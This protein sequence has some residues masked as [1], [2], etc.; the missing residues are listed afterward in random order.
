MQ[1]NNCLVCGNSDLKVFCDM[2]QMPLVNNLK[3]S[4]QEKDLIFPLLVNECP[5]CTHKQLSISVDRD[6]LFKDYLYQTGVSK[7][8]VDFFNKFVLSL[9]K[10]GT[11]VLDIGCN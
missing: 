11:N 9:E 2:G 7:S 3:E 1:L 10:F 6:L 5:V 4:P 8:H